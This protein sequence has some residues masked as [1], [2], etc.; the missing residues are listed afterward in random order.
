MKKT[1]RRAER[2]KVDRI[3]S[4]VWFAG[5]LLAIDRAE[6]S[7]TDTAERVRKDEVDPNEAAPRKQLR[8]AHILPGRAHDLVVAAVGIERRRDRMTG[9]HSQR[10]ASRLRLQPFHCG[11]CGKRDVRD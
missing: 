5:Y 3:G 1:V 9:S 6:P 11:C 10:D 7:L 8:H 4:V 2:H